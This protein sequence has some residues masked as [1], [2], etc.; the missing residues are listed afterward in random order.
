[1]EHALRIDVRDLELFYGEVQALKGITIPLKEHQIT[2]LIGG[3]GLRSPVVK[4]DE[5]DA[6]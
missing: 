3:K 6:F 4:D 2:A 1:M 5:T